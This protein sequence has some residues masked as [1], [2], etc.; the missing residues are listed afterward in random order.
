MNFFRQAPLLALALCTQISHA[1]FAPQIRIELKSKF[2]T[3]AYVSRLVQGIGKVTKQNTDGSFDVVLRPEMSTSVLKKLKLRPS[4]SR[5][6]SIEP[7]FDASNYLNKSCKNLSSELSE[8][9]SAWEWHARAEGLEEKDREIS[10]LDR[11]QAYLQRMRERSFPRDRIDYSGIFDLAQKR[12]GSMG[13]VNPTSGPQWEFIGPRNLDVPYRTYYGVRPCVGRVNA[14][15]YDPITAGTYY[16]GASKGGVWKTTDSGVNWIPLGDRWPLMGVSSVAVNPQNNQ[17]ILAGTGDFDGGD[18]IGFG[19]MRSSDGGSTWTQTGFSVMGGSAVSD[20]AYNPD[21]PNIVIATTGRGSGT[22][23][24]YRSLDSGQTWS[25]SLN[26]ASDWCGVDVS[27]SVS[28]VRTFWIIGTGGNKVYKSSDNG[29]SWT[30]VTIPS[31][32]TSVT[33]VACSKVNPGVVYVLDVGGQKIRKTI[34]TGTTWTDTTNNFSNQWGQ[35]WYDFH[36]GTSFLGTQD[37]VYVGLID[38]AMSKDS[39]ATWRNMGGANWTATYTGTAITHNDQHS[40]AVNPAN[41]LE[42]LVGNDGGVYKS[43]YSSTADTITWT[44]LNRLLGITQFYTLAMH[45]TNAAYA[46]GGTQDNASPHSFGDVNNWLNPGAGDGAGCLINPSNPANQYHS[47]YNQNIERTDN[48]FT[49]RTGITPSWAG[50]STPFIGKLW[51][52]PNN[53]D[54][55][56]ANTNYLNRYNRATNTW[57]QKLGNQAFGGVIQAFAAAKTDSNRLYVSMQN[58]L[59]MS[60]NFG[61]SWAR[62][63][64]QGA[65]DGIPVATVMDI[66]VSSTNA[67]DVIVVMGGTGTAKVLRCTNTSAAAPSWVSATS[68]LPDIHHI[69]FARDPQRPTTHWYVG[70]DGGVWRTINSGATWTE[71]T[72]SRGLPNVEI[73]ALVAV[74]GTGYLNAGTFGRGVWRVQMTAGA[75]TLAPTSQIFNLGQLTTGNLASLANDDANAEVVCKALVPTLTSPFINTQLR[76]TTSIKTPGQLDFRVKAKADNAG[77]FN[78]RLLMLNNSTSLDDEL[79]DASLATSYNTFVGN[80]GGTLSNY[81]NQSTGEIA[82]RI[83][84]RKTGLSATP[85]PCYSLEFAQ[86]NVQE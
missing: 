34:D 40:F 53:P 67:N 24:V 20:L 15:A 39:G 65:A 66:N 36:I 7:V 2:A 1:E 54:L 27:T 17:E 58:Q 52:D 12:L 37:M 48:S 75:E 74:S 25:V 68:G 29:A 45:P 6:E 62:I 81:V 72:G 73:D 78:I 26:I 50:H 16:A 59:W 31:L 22:G 46:L 3:I 85:S 4:V 51:F 18:S 64:R 28:G 84:I 9:E 77:V 19:V 44:M 35:G 33:D 55:V 14:L 47:W 30:L 38:I 69:C 32:G 11:L 82:A 86:V 10:G 13:E 60:T 70:N 76:Y 23:R 43:V 79:L 8:F 49:S 41:P 21:N 61:T 71:F 80:A 42:V 83:T 63:D 57:S 56:Y 5:V